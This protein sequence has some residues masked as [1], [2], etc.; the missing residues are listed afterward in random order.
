MTVQAWGSAVVLV[1]A[2]VLIGDA[3]SLLGARC[4]AAA[5]AVGLSVLIIVSFATIQLPGRAVTTVVVLAVLLI[6]AAVIVI[7]RRDLANFRFGRGRRSARSPALT[8]AA[9]AV[10][11]AVAAV[12]AAIPFIA[13]GHVGL[14]GVGFDNDTSAHLIWAQTL[15]SPVVGTRYGVLPT[16]YPLGPHALADAMSAGLGVRL[17]MAFNGLL[18][19]TLIITALVAAAALRHDSAWKIPLIGG[20]GAL[21]YLVAAY[22]AEGAFK[23]MLMGLLLL[24]M[25]LHLM[26]VTTE[27]A[28]RRRPL[29]Q[30][31]IPASLLVAASL[32]VYSYLALGWIVLT[33]GIWLLAE[34]VARPGWLRRWRVL[35]FEIA[36]GAAI[37]GVITFLLV[38]PAL[39]HI[40]SFAG[41]IG[42]SPAATGA[43]PVSNVG[44]IPHALPGWEAL[45]IWTSPDFRFQP[46]NVFNAHLLSWLN[47]D[48]L[49]WFALGV[50]LFGV[51]WALRRR[52]FLLPAAVAACAIV[53]WRAG[54]G[55][56]PYVTAKALVVAGPVI[57]VTGLRGLL[58][59]PLAPMPRPL[60]VGRYVAA[61]VFIA[62][63]GYSTY[64]V[65]RNEPV[66]PTES[67]RELLALDRLTRGQTVLFLGSSDYA[68]WIFHD[69]LMSSAPSIVSM[70][71][72]SIRSAKPNTY[73]AQLDW[74]SIDPTTI[75]RFTWAVTPNTTYTSQAPTGFQLVRRLPMYELWRRTATV[76]PRD[77]LDPPGAPGALFDCKNPAV[78][79]LSRRRGVAAVMSQP[80][81]TPLTSPGQLPGSPAVIPPGGFDSTTL[82]LPAGRWDLSLQ[83]NSGVPFDVIVGNVFRVMPAYLDRPGPYFSVG[84]VV[85]DGAPMIMLIHARRP[86]S[87]SGRDLA[88]LPSSV[89]AT[90][91]PDTRTLVPLAQACG[92]YVDWFR[93]QS[94]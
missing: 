92:R 17:D 20:L 94:S 11:L 67:T 50:L 80:V 81:S 9:V 44:N 54:Q 43:I 49:S 8:A 12:G 18:I 6:A 29:W 90:R 5:P 72:V 53:F 35:A 71:Q 89:V 88:A 10:T 42:L 84:S 19:A 4:R 58:Q 27:S 48:L 7:V 69:S 34:V 76:Q 68:A 41:S 66:W 85:S 13:N 52:E 1:A 24:A 63:A 51:G 77:A 2:S 40:V 61:A 86:S 37:A 30:S 64:Q 21:S 70:G 16:G 33:L 31:L 38:L 73:G 47:G 28:A 75:N 83:Y 91:S 65:L 3:I 62:L 36:P 23:E 22:Y 79:Q 78:R 26:E 15:A 56:S 55:Q 93:I 60:W 59:A 46:I 14:L 32:Y 45:G 87:I 25:V 57:A 39:G 74:D 82:R